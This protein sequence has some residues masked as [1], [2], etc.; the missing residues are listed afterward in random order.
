MTEAR[1]LFSLVSSLPGEKRHPLARI[2]SISWANVDAPQ[3]TATRMRVEGGLEVELAEGIAGLREGVSSGELA[4]R[5]DNVR[6][7]VGDCGLLSN[8]RQATRGRRGSSG[9]P[10][11]RLRRE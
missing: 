7:R 10:P 8:G 11:A 2:P 1:R 6:G 9:A 4:S 5:V 3:H